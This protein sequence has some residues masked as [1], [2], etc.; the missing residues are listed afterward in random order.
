MTWTSVTRGH[1]GTNRLGVPVSASLAERI[2]C[3]G[4]YDFSHG[5]CFIWDEGACNQPTR[6]SFCTMLP[7]IGDEPGSVVLIWHSSPWHRSRDVHAT[8]AQLG[9]ILM[10]LP[11]VQT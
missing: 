2:N 9:F 6:A 11:T 3:Y 7:W 4:T 8:A 10:A 5:Q 1:P